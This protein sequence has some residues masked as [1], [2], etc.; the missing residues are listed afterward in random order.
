MHNG[1]YRRYYPEP[2]AGVVCKSRS[3]AQHE[4]LG[5][6]LRGVGNVKIH[7]MVCEAFHGLAPFEKAV[8]IHI[9]ENAL[10]NR[11]DN[12][13]WGTQKENL[14]AP[15]FKEYCR[16]RMGAESPRAKWAAKRVSV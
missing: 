16:N 11:A 7:R 8:V 6:W 5:A 1:G 9:D 13:K 2:F 3:S 15:G 4:Y 14:N 12:L 10:N